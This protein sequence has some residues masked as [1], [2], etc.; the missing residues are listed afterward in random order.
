MKR[1]ATAA[2][3][4]VAAASLMLAGSAL[5]GTKTY[6]Q[7]GHVVGDKGSL[8]KLRVKVK[9]GDP[10]QIKGFKANNV[11]T[12][13]DTKNGRKV[14]RYDYFSLDPITIDSDNEFDIVLTNS[15]IGLKISLD[16]DVKKHG[17][18]VVGEIKTNKFTDKGKTCKA[19]EQEFRTA[20]R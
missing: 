1:T 16:G 2:I 13:C 14:K 3:T 15:A 5:A 9:N 17:K 6:K 18:K 10:K 11:I 19:P 4:L 20:K 7:T 12:R 8:V